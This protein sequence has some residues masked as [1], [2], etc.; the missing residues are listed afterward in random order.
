MNPLTEAAGLI[1]FVLRHPAN[2]GRAISALARFVAW[3]A[4]KRVV[5]RPRDLRFR[6]GFRLRAWP[7][8][9]V[10]SMMIYCRGRP[11]WH[12][13]LFLRHFL[14]PGDGFVDVG[15][16]VGTYSLLAGALVGPSG[17]VEAFEP[18]ADAAQR[19]RLNIE[20]NGF[21]WVH[22][23]QAAVGAEEGTVRFTT[24][25]KTINQ[26]SL[27]STPGD[28]EVSQ[29]R[30]DDVLAGRDAAA[31]KL[32]VE[33]AEPLVLAGWQ[34]A[35]RRGL[36]MALLIEVNDG[37]RRFGFREAEFLGWLRGFGYRMGLYDSDRRIIRWSEEPWR[38]R[39]NILAIHE[40]SL[41]K[42]LCRIEGQAISG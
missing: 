24:G 25:L 26:V 23:T 22:L 10:A 19:F 39:E 36:P 42:I 28:V 9:T 30:L 29:L 7:D 2:R 1:R 11:D 17:W 3:Q 33:G 16:H 40:P 35:L 15:A 6:D 21:S 20:L 18:A 12:E 31:A 14:K 38:E 4:W 8:S 27:R 13:A 34:A 37:I 41:D 5:G 32:D